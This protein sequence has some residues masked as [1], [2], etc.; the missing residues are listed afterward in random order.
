MSESHAAQVTLPG[1]GDSVGYW[2]GDTLVIDTIGIKIGPFAMVDA[3]GTPQSP[4]LHVLERYRLI[5]YERRCAGRN[6]A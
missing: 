6:G 3:Y 2:E 1:Y 5:D 4:A